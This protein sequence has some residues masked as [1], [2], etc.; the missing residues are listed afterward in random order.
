MFIIID[1]I[2]N[3]FLDNE[4]A[5]FVVGT[6]HHIPSIY[7]AFMIITDNKFINDKI[8]YYSITSN[9]MITHTLAYFIYDSIY[10][11]IYSFP[12]NSYK[13]LQYIIHALSCMSVYMYFYNSKKYHYY[14]AAFLTFECSTPFLYTA[15]LM[16]KYNMKSNIVF[17]INSL[18]LLA[19]FF[20]FR[21]LYGTYIIW[22]DMAPLFVWYQYIPAIALTSLNYLWFYKLVNKAIKLKV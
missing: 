4:T 19:S 18:L 7:Y 1:K 21:I 10:Y 12:I 20:I 13:K 8:N 16:Y 14:G 22:Y 5:S 9:T 11:L 3:C 6:V 15:L 17:K 2:C